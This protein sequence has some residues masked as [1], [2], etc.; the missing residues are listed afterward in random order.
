MLEDVWLSSDREAT[1]CLELFYLK[2][3]LPRKQV[4]GQVLSCEDKQPLPGVTINI[5][6]TIQ[7]KVVYTQTTAGDGNILLLVCIKQG[8][9]IDHVSAF[10][11]AGYHGQVI[12]EIVAEM[13]LC[14]CIN[15]DGDV[16]F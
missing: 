6:D 2:K 3:V 10:P 16:A 4:V 7:N 1:C 5:L 12:I 11:P 8:R 14:T 15:K 13:Q 9:E